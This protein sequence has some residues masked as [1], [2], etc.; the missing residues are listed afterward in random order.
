MKGAVEMN[1]ITLI[2][3][4]G[5]GKSTIGVLLAKRLGLDFVDTDILI[6]TEQKA[7]LQDVLD[8]MGVERF[9][10]LEGETLGALTCA[11]TVIAPGGS[12]VCR[13]GAMENLRRLG[14]VVYIKLPYEAIEPRITNLDRRGIAFRPGE[15]LRSIYEERTPLY[16]RYADITVETD[17]LTLEQSAAA[18]E[19]ALRQS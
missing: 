12:C 17:G 9:L 2:G 3:M 15:T 13:A 5:P 8:S 19:R 14:K 1:C 16:E 4:P 11:G 7:Q 6:Q 10:D 18:V